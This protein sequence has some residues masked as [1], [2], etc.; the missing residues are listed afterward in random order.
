[1][2]GVVTAVGVE[3]LSCGTEL[4]N[5]RGSMGTITMKMIRSTSSTS[6]RGV[7][8]IS[9]EM[10]A[11]EPEENAMGSTSMQKSVRERS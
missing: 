5:P 7:T 8:L 1:M 3:G 9:E 10:E 4:S 11:D 6:I 2:V